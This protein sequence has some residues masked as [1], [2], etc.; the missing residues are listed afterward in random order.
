MSEATPRTPPFGKYLF[1]FGL[2][3]FL[4]VPLVAYL[5]ETVHQILSLHFETTRM[6]VSIP[7]LAMFIGLLK[8]IS[9]QLGGE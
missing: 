8:F 6:L 1:V 3:L 2:F 7:V 4:G 9:H 5:W